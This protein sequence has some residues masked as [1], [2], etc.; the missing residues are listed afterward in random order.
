MKKE[1]KSES[2]QLLNLMIHSI[3]SNKDV[4]LRELVSNASDALDKRS[5]YEISSELKNS[6]E[7]KISIVVNKGQRIITISDTGIGLSQDELDKNLGTI[8]H[9]GSKEFME[10]LEKKE[11]VSVIGQ[12]GV[13]FYSSFIISDNVEVIS[14]KLGE[15]AYKFVSD[16]VSE[17]EISE[18][19]L[20][21]HGTK[22]ILNV[23][24]GEEYDKYLDENEVESLVVKHN[25][26]VKYPIYLEKSQTT[27]NDK[28]EEITELTNDVINSQVAIWKK[29]KSDITPEEYNEFYKSKFSDFTDPLKVIHSHA[30]GVQTL[31]ILLYIPSKKGYDYNTPTFKKGLDLYSKGILIDHNVEYLLPD[32]FSF[33]KGLVDSEDINL[34]VSREMLQKDKFVDK[35]KKSIESKVKKE[36]LKMQ[37]KKREDYIKFYE[38]FGRTICFGVY[39]QFGMMA[40]EL[41]DLLMFKTS[42]DENYVTL[43]EY[44]ENNK[45][46]ENIYYISGSSIE[47]IKS[48][49][50]MEKALDKNIEILYLTQD[51]E[52]FAIQGLREY[53]GKA[54]MSLQ[55]ANFEDDS[56]KEELEK[57]A[58]QNKDIID[59]IKEELKEV[60]TDVR[61]TTK[62]SKSAV[63]LV[64]EGDVSIEQEKLLSM[65]PDN[66]FSANKI[67]EINAEHQLF[68]K[69]QD[70]ESKIN[71][72][73]QLL[74]DQALLISGLELKDPAKH[75]QL[76]NDL[77]INS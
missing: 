73:S 4:F 17:Y 37:S 28:D 31:D 26:Y 24:E 2:K 53:E 14:K 66:N 45:E 11:D 12:F 71:V 64:N 54:F 42:R 61:F 22:I 19:E 33:V 6:D 50:L 60:V 20:D 56:E 52:E 32:Y 25:D 9:S 76:I 5:F 47:H 57:L 74:Y 29:K 67:L 23:R 59:K 34:N 39:D 36:L 8:A 68:K 38:E 77:I 13:G 58:E 10:Q 40:K 21:F 1:F 27:K 70:D 51:I 41:Q 48:Q 75:A 35:I 18:S 43:K 55:N 7:K 65:M 46:T 69:L 72:V 3:Y 63:V 30:E 44:M 62:L 49:P 15:K 16:G